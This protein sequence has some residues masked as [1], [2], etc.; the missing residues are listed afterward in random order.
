MR[1]LQ[2]GCIQAARQRCV[3]EGLEASRAARGFCCRAARTCRQGFGRFNPP[4]FARFTVIARS[5][6]MESQSH[7]IDAV[8]KRYI[9]EQTRLELDSLAVSALEEVTGPWNICSRRK[10]SA[11]PAEHVNGVSRRAP[12]A[13]RAEPRTANPRTPNRRTPNRRTQN[14]RTKNPEPNLNTNREHTERRRVNPWVDTL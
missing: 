8:D 12:S 6:I 11:M 14:N 1:R 13:S 5:S 7:L 9:T 4:D 2:E 3:R 10:R